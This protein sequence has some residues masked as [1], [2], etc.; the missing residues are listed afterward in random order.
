MK[1]KGLWFMVFLLGVFFSAQAIDHVKGDGKLMT[2]KIVIDDY[3]SIKIED[4]VELIYEQSDSV[5]YLEVTL[6]ENLH[7]YVNVNINNRELTVGFKGAS[8]D[9]FTKYV[10]KTNSKWLKK[11]N[12]SDVASVTI[13]GAIKGDE[14][15]LIASSNGIV[16][17]S[18]T[19][20]VSTLS[21]KSSSKG[22]I[23]LNDAQVGKLSCSVL[24]SG[25]IDLKAGKADEASMEIA[26]SGNI[27]AV[28]V[29]VQQVNCKIAGAGTAV[30]HPTDN[31]KATIVG[32]GTIRY[33]GPTAVQQKIIGKGTVE[34]I[35]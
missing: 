8:V 17:A 15:L 28:N 6:D 2:K 19:I 24:T 33:K 21:L 31:L 12:A 5:P 14:L 11:V 35:K 20:T 4:A 16:Q 9:H 30:V 23:T 10:V 29:A 1:T 3:N 25:M 22:K 18:G 34:E 26:T 27:D 32:K 13:N 7:Q